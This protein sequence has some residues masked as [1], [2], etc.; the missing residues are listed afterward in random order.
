MPCNRYGW[1]FALTRHKWFLEAD[2]VDWWIYSTC[3]QNEISRDLSLRWVSDGCPV[4]H[5]T[6]EVLCNTGHPSETH[7]KLKSR[8]ISFFH[9]TRVNNPI[10]LIFCTEHDSITA[11]LRVK[12]QNDWTTETDVIDEQDFARFEFKMSFARI[13]YITQ[14]RGFDGLNLFAKGISHPPPPKYLVLVLRY[15]STL[16]NRSRSRD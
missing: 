11:V 5:S 12:C 16:A 2:P 14:H 15:C 8:E 10:I 3:H 9:N 4:L 6:T 13:S 1:Y 7:L